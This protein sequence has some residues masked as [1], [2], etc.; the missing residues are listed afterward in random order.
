MNLKMIVF[1]FAVAQC[2]RSPL[3]KN[4]SNF[5]LLVKK[6]TEAKVLMSEDEVKSKSLAL[7]DLPDEK[8]CD[9]VE[10]LLQNFHSVHLVGTELEELQCIYTAPSTNTTTFRISRQETAIAFH[11]EVKRAEI[12]VLDYGATKAAFTMTLRKVDSDQKL[13]N[14]NPSE[15]LRLMHVNIFHLEKTLQHIFSQGRISKSEEYCD[16]KLGRPFD[17][18]TKNCVFRLGEDIGI[19]ANNISALDDAKDLEAQLEWFIKQFFWQK[20]SPTRGLST[21]SKKKPAHQNPSSD[22]YRISFQRDGIADTLSYRLQIKMAK[23]QIMQELP[24][25][26]KNIRALVEVSVVKLL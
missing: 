21:P 11:L 4:P 10:D 22:I 13:V 6:P 17:E 1:S 26:G 19:A 24:Q 14:W 12:E 5:E 18:S 23:R 15:E 8:H 25:L 16:K 9:V 3:S 7:V 2:T 20:I